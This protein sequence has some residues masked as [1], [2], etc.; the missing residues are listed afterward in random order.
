MASWSLFVLY[1]SGDTPLEEV[2]DGIRG[3]LR[4]TSGEFDVTRPIGRML[5]EEEKQKAIWRA[6]F[7]SFFGLYDV[8]LRNEQ[9]WQLMNYTKK[10][11]AASDTRYALQ[12]VPASQ[13]QALKG[14]VAADQVDA[15]RFYVEE[16]RAKVVLFCSEIA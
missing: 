15:L 7:W 10:A 8:D 16:G 2:M 9:L 4:E 1:R 13:L 5:T 12:L 3:P 11:A 14:V 6:W